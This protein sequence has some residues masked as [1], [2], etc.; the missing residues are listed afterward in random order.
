MEVGSVFSGRI[1]SAHRAGGTAGERG[2]SERRGALD[3]DD[4]SVKSKSGRLVLDLRHY[5]LKYPDT[6]VAG[7]SA[8]R[9]SVFR[10]PPYV[11][12]PPAERST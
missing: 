1:R 7:E 6:Q 2:A 3:L 11:E 4:G 9:A 12:I 10:S 8:C 5:K